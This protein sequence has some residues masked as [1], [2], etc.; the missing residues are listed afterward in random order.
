[1]ACPLEAV[2]VQVPIALR[3]VYMVRPSNAV[4]LKKKPKKARV[5]EVKNLYLSLKATRGVYSTP[6]TRGESTNS[7]RMVD[8][9]QRAGED[10]TARYETE[11][12]TSTGFL[13][14][15][16]T[17]ETRRHTITIDTD[18]SS[19]RSVIRELNNSL[20]PRLSDVESSWW[21]KSHLLRMKH[22]SSPQQ[23]MQAVSKTRGTTIA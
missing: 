7:K 15:A 10:I 12:S 14:N 3:T 16:C 8:V 19:K 17:Q 1:M 20:E 9:F 21:E 23:R 18:L 22:E 13:N 4:P 5:D 11:Y 6:S 2:L